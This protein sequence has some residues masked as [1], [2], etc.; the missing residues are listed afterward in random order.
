MRHLGLL[1]DDEIIS[2][3]TLDKYAKLFERPLAIDVI[4]AFAE[5]YGWEV[6][7]EE[8]LLALHQPSPSAIVAA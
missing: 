6:P 4:Q 7:S 5:F 8:M 1:Q 2:N 3:T